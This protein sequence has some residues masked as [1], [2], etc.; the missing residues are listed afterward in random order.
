MATVNSCSLCHLDTRPV[1]WQDEFCRVVGVETLDYPGYCR[2]ILNAHVVEMSDL[3]ENDRYR[4]IQV[5]LATE[6][7]VRAVLKPTKI[8]LASL[9]NQVPHLHWHVIP[10][11]PQDPTFP[12]AIWA[13]SRR[14]P[15]VPQI[16][17][18]WAMLTRS[19]QERLDY[20]RQ[21]GC[22]LHP[23]A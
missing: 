14:L 17:D 21:S 6:E 13:S 19:L 1:L 15:A 22:G 18:L 11:W 23:K 4:L 5:V 9:G 3:P 7:A 12:D 16:A 2:V 20:L 8:N 10:R